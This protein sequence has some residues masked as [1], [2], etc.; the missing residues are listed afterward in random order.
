MRPNARNVYRPVHSIFHGEGERTLSSQNVKRQ[1]LPQRL[2]PS[3]QI[4]PGGDAE[5][6]GTETVTCAIHVCL[7]RGASEGGKWTHEEHNEEET[8]LLLLLL[9]PPPSSP[10]TTFR[11]IS[12]LKASCWWQSTSSLSHISLL[13]RQSGSHFQCTSSTRS[14]CATSRPARR[15]LGAR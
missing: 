3:E 5:F 9:N 12:Y 8:V 14:V 15:N 4:V 6:S 11:S 1:K 10:L 7:V 2:F 13:F